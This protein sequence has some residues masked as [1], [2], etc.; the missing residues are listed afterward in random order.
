[1]FFSI[2]SGEDFRYTN[3]RVFSLDGQHISRCS[4]SEFSYGASKL[5]EASMGVFSKVTHLNDVKFPLSSEFLGPEKMLLPSFVADLSN[6]QVSQTVDNG[7]AESDGSVDR[8]SN[9]YSKKRREMDSTTILQSGSSVKL[10]GIPK[11]R[12]SADYLP[13]EDDIL[14]SILGNQWFKFVYFFF[15]QY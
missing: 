4:P 6:D 9:H 12:R 10:S 2:L 15:V 5:D 13:S 8:Y 1:M 14:A 3:D 7:V 11:G